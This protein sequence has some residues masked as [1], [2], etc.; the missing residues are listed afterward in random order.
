MSS[1]SNAA[2]GLAA[3]P[4]ADASRPAVAYLLWTYLGFTETFLYR[5]MRSLERY[6]GLVLCARL[7]NADR[8]PWDGPVAVSVRQP[9]RALC[10]VRPLHRFAPLDPAWCKAI[11]RQGARVL[12]AQYGPNGLLASAY[13][14]RFGL[15]LVTS[16][17]GYDVGYLEAALQHLRTHW[18]YM[19][20][21]AALFS[22]SRVVLALSRAMRDD[23]VRLG[24]PPDKIRVHPNGVDLR[25]FAPVP[26]ADRGGPVT[27]V[28]CGRA[29]E[30]KG[31][32]YGFRAL[33]RARDA[34][35]NLRA[36]WLI[37]PGPL[38]ASL[39]ALIDD[40]G[41]GPHVEILDPT[42][43]PAALM[44]S[45][46][47][48]L[49]PSVTAKSGDKEGV[50]T[51]LVEAAASGLPAVGSRHAGIPEVVID[52]ES[53]FLYGERDVQ[54]LAAGL[55]TLASDRDLRIRMGEAACRLAAA[56]YDAGKLARRL[57]EVYDDLRGL[58]SHRGT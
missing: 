35:A 4:A 43:D 41:L 30:K 1:R 54:G 23:L 25:R 3:A 52:G 11:A 22:S 33:R 27:V 40:L 44:A 24:C 42:G 37:A 39:R 7:A 2:S 28:L 20:G 47:I 10:A 46:D 12:H 26:R 32:E 51:V 17:Y 53:G 16:F 5:Q 38:E 48:I 13:A 14:S 45:G 9:H 34:G 29:D 36:R 49:A 58:A 18:H 50:P 55:M 6:R 8:F 31:F 57:E 15:P 21:R 19:L 56:T